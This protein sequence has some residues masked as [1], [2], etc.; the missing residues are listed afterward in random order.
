MESKV[1]VMSMVLAQFDY[2]DMRISA[3]QPTRLFPPCIVP[4]IDAT[5]TSSDQGYLLQHIL[6]RQFLKNVPVCTL[7][8]KPPH[9]KHG[10]VNPCKFLSC[11]AASNV[12][13]AAATFLTFCPYSYIKKTCSQPL[14]LILHAYVIMQRA[15]Y[16]VACFYFIISVRSCWS[17]QNITN[18]VLFYSSSAQ[19]W[20][21]QDRFFY[22]GFLFSLTYHFLCIIFQESTQSY[23][24]VSYS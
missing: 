24:F 6:G 17:M 15:S 11:S 23:I 20:M 3:T 5:S 19:C 21:W 22:I 9:P 12:I 16:L 2:L 1:V 18:L 14:I 7:N 8:L 4:S 13:A 10:S